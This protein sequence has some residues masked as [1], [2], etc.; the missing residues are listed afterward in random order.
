MSLQR[1]G[2]LRQPGFLL[3]LIVLAVVATAIVAPTPRHPPIAPPRHPTNVPSM[4]KMR[5]MS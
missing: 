1:M 5:A 2:L 4:R 3:S